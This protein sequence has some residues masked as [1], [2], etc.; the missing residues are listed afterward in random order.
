M[1]A[2]EAF[3]KNFLFLSSQYN[4]FAGAAALIWS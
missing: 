4:E 1:K 2:W 3:F